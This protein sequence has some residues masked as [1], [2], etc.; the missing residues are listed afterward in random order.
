MQY[1]YISSLASEILTRIARLTKLTYI[2]IWYRPH[3]IISEFPLILVLKF[4]QYST[5]SVDYII[6]YK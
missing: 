1:A 5:W 6:L 2:L 4:P 3:Y